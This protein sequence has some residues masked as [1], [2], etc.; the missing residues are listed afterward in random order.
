MLVGRFDRPNLIYRVV[1]RDDLDAQML[2]QCSAATRARR[3]SSTASA[4]RTPR[5][6]RRAC[7]PS[8]VKAAPYHAGI[9]PGERARTQEAFAAERID[10]VVATVAFGMG[11]DR[12]NVRCVIH[13]AMPKS[14]EHYQQET[15]RAG[16]D[17]LEA[18][19]VLFYSPQDV[20]RWSFIFEKSEASA[21]VLSAQKALLRDMRNLCESPICRHA[22]LSRYFGQQYGTESCDACDICN[23]SE[24]TVAAES[25]GWKGVDRE[26]FERL[27][28]VRR[29]IAEE[30]KVPAYVVFSDATLRD[31]ARVR[32]QTLTEMKRI[33]GIGERRLADLGGRF[34]GEIRLYCTENGISFSQA[35]L[36]TNAPAVR[37]PAAPA[38]NLTKRR[39]FDLFDAGRSIAEVADELGRAPATV[40]SYLGDYI[41]EARPPSVDPWVPAPLFRRI[42]A[43]AKTTGSGLLRPVFEALG[44]QVPYDDIRIVMTFLRAQRELSTA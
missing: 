22:A 42:S 20:R 40:A 15:G 7:R 13:A 31:L 1:P 4:A 24:V 10:V 8:G 38:V 23:P 21:D 41:A 30:R 19:C 39:A 9:D 35:P 25:D 17:G 29:A 5:R 43:A 44:G 27:R 37:N 2:R 12:S 18:E 28:T 26:L 33:K 3:A 32:P 11:I 6:W 34:L 16:R 36:P 14:I